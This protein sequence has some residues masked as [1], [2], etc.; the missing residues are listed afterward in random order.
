M[1]YSEAMKTLALVTN[2]V[3][4][5]ISLSGCGAQSTRSYA[6]IDQLLD[7]FNKAGGN[8]SDW[9]QDNRVSAALQSGTCDSNTVLM[10]FGSKEEATERALEI[11]NTMKSFDLVPNLLLGENWLINSE[12]VDSIAPKLSGILIS[13]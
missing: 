3:L 13:D 7:A 2:V 5:A 6:D 1:Q 4:I 11:K 9:V 10:L 8:C 12:Q